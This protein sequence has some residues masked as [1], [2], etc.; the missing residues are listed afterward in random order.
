MLKKTFLILIFLFGTFSGYGQ[1][2]FFIENGKKSAKIKFDLVNNL[3]TVPVELN[4]AHLTFL[5]DTGVNTTVLLNLEEADSLQLKN[6]QKVNLRGLGGEELIEAYKSE[7]NHLKIGN[8]ISENLTVYLIYNEGVNFSPRLGVAVNGI[9][10][11][12]FF[13]DFVVEINYARKFL[14]VYDPDSFNKQ[15]SNY[16][17]VVLRFFRNKPYVQS[18]V[19]IE[20]KE[21][22]TTLLI[23]NGMGDAVWLF[24]ENSDIKVPARSFDDFLGLG[25][26]GDVIGKRS[27]I[28][29]LELGGYRLNDV[30]AAFPDSISVQGLKMFDARDGSVGAEILRR[31]NMFIDY[32]AQRIFLRKNKNFTD[33]FNY[34]MSGIIVEHSGFVIVE[35]YMAVP[36]SDKGFDQGEVVVIPERQT[37][38]S[39]ELQPAFHIV[40]V[41][42]DSPA[43]RAGLQVGDVLISIN[44]KEAYKYDLEEIVALFSSEEGKKIR[45]EVSRGLQNLKFDFKLEKVL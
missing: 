21:L 23:D 28:K 19:E 8:A 1:K 3:I 24:N 10:G 34:D 20:G 31:F 26:V 27:R 9:I 22:V 7:N 29:S 33:P 30:T 38:K 2:G 32:G 37:Q 13:K 6:A 14:R 45:L 41:R 35:T 36:N 16:N 18:R 17:E 15:L 25:L 11:Y 42:K 5:L 39:F 44:G 12:D 43:Y 40:S 4:G